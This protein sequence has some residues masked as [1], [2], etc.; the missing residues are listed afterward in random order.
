[1]LPHPADH[2][3]LRE[4]LAIQSEDPIFNE[5]LPTAWAFAVSSGVK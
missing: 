1:M 4:E 2:L 5:A 3:L